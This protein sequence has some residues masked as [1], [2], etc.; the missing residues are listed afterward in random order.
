MNAISKKIFLSI[1]FLS[2]MGLAMPSDSVAS[3]QDART[4]FWNKI[5]SST[6]SKV[7]EL[8]HGNNNETKTPK[9]ELTYSVAKALMQYF[10]THPKV[11]KID[12]LINRLLNKLVVSMKFFVTTQGH[13]TAKIES[14]LNSELSQIPAS[15]LKS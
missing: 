8:V 5:Y 1:I 7:T 9:D 6:Q 12:P 10:D 2:L 15:D 14:I 3:Q 4:L 13:S 11:A